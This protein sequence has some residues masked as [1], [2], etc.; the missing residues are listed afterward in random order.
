MSSAIFDPVPNS[1]L[2]LPLE[3]DVDLF[4]LKGRNT[5]TIASSPKQPTY[6]ELQRLN[7]KE[8]ERP[9]RTGQPLHR[10]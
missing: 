6:I 3:I 8:S 2:Q 10:N 9:A 4:D 1:Y 5:V 7:C